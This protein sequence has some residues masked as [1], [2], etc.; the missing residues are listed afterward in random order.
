MLII[1]RTRCSYYFNTPF[2]VIF[3]YPQ[4][5]RKILDQ[6]EKQYSLGLH[7][8]FFRILC[9]MDIF[10]KRFII[11]HCGITINISNTWSVAVLTNLQ[12]NLFF[13]VLQ[14]SCKNEYISPY[15]ICLSNIIISSRI[16]SIIFS[17]KDFSH[18]KI[19]SYPSID[20]I[21]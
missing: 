6:K 21:W 19:D 13:S 15:D 3:Q 11:N 4:S 14:K 7:D 8:F 1:I 12:F 10:F 17:I 2:C 5:K 18:K 16:I 20:I 9:R